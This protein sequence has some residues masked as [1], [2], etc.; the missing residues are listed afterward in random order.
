MLVRVILFLGISLAVS[1]YGNFSLLARSHEAKYFPVDR[2][3]AFRD[4]VPLSRP[5]APD[6]QIMNWGVSAVEQAYSMD[7]ANYRTQLQKLSQV[8]T[9][10][11]YDGFEKALHDSGNMEAIVRNKYV[12]EAGLAGT[13]VIT[14]QGVFFGRYAWKMQ[15]PLRVTYESSARTT[16]QVLNITAVVVRQSALRS[17]DGLALHQILAR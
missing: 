3:T 1:I 12:V 13:P 11:G 9:K 4:L 6:S 17:G 2:K 8:M 14:K 15:F 5:N 16:T 7:F 10:S